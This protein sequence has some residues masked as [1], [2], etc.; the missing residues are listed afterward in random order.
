MMVLVVGGSGSGKSEYAEKTADLLFGECLEERMENSEESSVVELSV[1][2]DA[3]LQNAGKYY[4]ATMQ[5]F[6]EEGRKKVERHKRL[7]DGK[8]FVTLEQATDVNRALDK[9]NI[10][11]RI[12]LLEC[13][14][15]LAANEMFSGTAPKSESEAVDKIIQEVKELADGTTHLVI[16]TNNVFEDGVCYDEPTMA[17]LRVMGRVNRELA[18]MADRVIEV[19]AGIPITI[20]EHGRSICG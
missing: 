16:V 9:M 18:R 3:A 1:S 13:M 19:V 2:R 4:L 20:K 15:N 17:Y 12:V 8:G 11:K 10:G 6:D 14:S 7:R 5:I